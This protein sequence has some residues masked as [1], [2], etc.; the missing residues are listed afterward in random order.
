[1][2]ENQLRSLLTD[3]AATVQDNPD[4]VR[5]VR[6]RVVGIRRRRAAAAVLAVLALALA[7]LTVARLP[8]APATLPAGSPAGP[9]FADDGA[10]RSV[11]G[12]QGSGYFAFAGAARWSLS[13][14]APNLPYV[15]V[16]R[17]EHRGDL[18]LGVSG[19]E[20]RVSCRVPV[21]DHYEGALPL[22]AATGPRS[23]EVPVRPGSG[24]NWTVGV[25]QPLFPDRLTREEV[26]D[27][28]LAGFGSPGGGRMTVALPSTVDTA[29]TMVVAAV[30]VRDVRLELTLDGR[31]LAEIG[32]DDAH[33]SAPGVVMAQVPAGTVRAL[34]LRGLQRV[35]IDVRSVGRP[36]GQWAI[37]GLG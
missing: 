6:S 27:A 18:E 2:I 31:P 32:C 28:L 37:I 16:V 33:V 14:P 25:L 34:G 7:G 24:G 30:C 13:L 1:V 5:E 12:Y 35:T 11:R 21:G 20:R 36:T 9:Y 10:A 15:I 19:A 23:E 29:G 26:P 8:G 17:C 3:R 4:R 22:T